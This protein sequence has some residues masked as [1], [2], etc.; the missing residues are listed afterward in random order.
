MQKFLTETQTLNSLSY[1][2]SCRILCYYKNTTNQ[3]QIARILNITNWY[4]EKVVFPGEQLLFEAVPEAELE[5][6]TGK[7][8]DRISADKI[9]C[10]RLQVQG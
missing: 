5:I 7:A 1:Q 4:F 3:I 9:I 10:D 2:G 6:H 8:V